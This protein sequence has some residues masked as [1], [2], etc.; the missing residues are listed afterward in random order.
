MHVSLSV[1]A[2]TMVTAYFFQLPDNVSLLGFAFF[3]TIVCYNFVK[4]GVEAEKY[5]IVYNSYHK[6]IQL[7]SFLCFLPAVYFF[8]QLGNRTRLAILVLGLLS[9]LYAVPFLPKN[10]NLRSLGGFKIYIVAA[11]WAGFTV[12]LPLLE[13]E[14]S[15]S[16]DVFLLLAQRFIL[17]LAL[18]LPFEIRDLRWD[19]TRLRTIPQVLGIE[20]TK[21]F[22]MVLVA[23][24]FFLTFLKDE[25]TAIEIGTRFVVSI[26][27]LVVFVLGKNMR[28][29][30][31]A[32]FWVEGV[33]M[34]WFGILWCL[35]QFL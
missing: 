13:Q 6:T 8:L 4:Y 3:G 35:E 28:Q 2:L 20:K 12:I 16:W 24:F 10:K 19:D 1:V 33:P 17:V 27:L 14:V 31:L 18:I 30:Y 5:L 29:K 32:S 26:I 23:F 21:R 11:V 34:F 22:G 9:V 25:L 15:L 7:F